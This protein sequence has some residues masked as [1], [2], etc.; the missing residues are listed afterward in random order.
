M[1]ESLEELTHRE[2]LLSIIHLKEGGRNFLLT[3]LKKGLE[4]AALEWPQVNISWK[5]ISTVFF[6]KVFAEYFY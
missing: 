6:F 2:I 1:A 3:E 4:Y 5:S